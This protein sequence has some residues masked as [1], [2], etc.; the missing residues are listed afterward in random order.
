[1][2]TP[3][4]GDSTESPQLLKVRNSISAASDASARIAS[5]VVRWIEIDGFDARQVVERLRHL[6]GERIRV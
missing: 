2:G 1:M 3:H 6:Y 4:A 5:A